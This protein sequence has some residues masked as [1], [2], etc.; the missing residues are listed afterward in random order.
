MRP[1]CVRSLLRASNLETGN[2]VDIDAG[3]WAL[4]SSLL[5]MH[6]RLGTVLCRG[7]TRVPHRE[8]GAGSKEWGASVLPAAPNSANFAA[9]TLGQ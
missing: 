8:S 4:G 7:C 2:G 6:D 3:G 5:S 1:Q 9:V